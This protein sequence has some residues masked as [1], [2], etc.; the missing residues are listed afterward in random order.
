MIPL[1]GDGV[2]LPRTDGLTEALRDADA[3]PVAEIEAEPESVTLTVASA[4]V[5]DGDTV[6][7]TAVAVANGIDALTEG[8]T[9]GLSLN[10]E[11]Y[12]IVG[13]GDVDCD[14][15]DTSDGE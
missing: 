12:D 3:T 10:D 5:A 4:I 11:T 7:P 1:L 6:P 14:V 13:T 9:L 2:V 15:L 8:E